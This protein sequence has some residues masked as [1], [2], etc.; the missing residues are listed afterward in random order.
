MTEG[1]KIRITIPIDPDQPML[2]PE[3]AMMVGMDVSLTLSKNRGD[4]F[5]LNLGGGKIESA[6]VEDVED[7]AIKQRLVLVILPEDD[8]EEEVEELVPLSEIPVQ[9]TK[10]ESK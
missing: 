6:T 9:I 3:A 8:T 4:F 1:E 2:A 5:V 10:G 7:P